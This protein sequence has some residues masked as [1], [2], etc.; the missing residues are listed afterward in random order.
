MKE[1]NWEEYL[2][3]EKLFYEGDSNMDGYLGKEDILKL[4][5]TYFENLENIDERLETLF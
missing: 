5:N 4:F 2:R 3:I 1:L